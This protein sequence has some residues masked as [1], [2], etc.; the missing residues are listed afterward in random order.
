MH[1]QVD[2]TNCDREPIHLLGRVQEFGFLVAVSQDWV[3]SHASQNI[4]D[5]LG[6]DATSLIGQPSDALLPPDTIHTIRNRL[7]FLN[8]HRGVEVIYDLQLCGTEARFD[9][10]VHRFESVIILEFE[11]A[12]PVEGAANDMA[13]VRNAIDRMAELPSFA[14]V[15][16]HTVRFVKVITGFDRVMLYKFGADETGEVVA[17][18]RKHDLEPFLNLRY[19]ATDIPKQARALYIENPIRLIGSVADEGSPILSDNDETLDLSGSRLRSVSPIHLEYL[20]NMNVGASMSISVIVNGQLWGLIACHHGKRHVPSMRLRNAALLFGH[21]LSLV[22]QTRLS[23]DERA[24]DE[25]VNRLTAH[26]SRTLS[27]DTTTPDLL[28]SSAE[29]FADILNADGYAVVQEKMVVGGGRTPSEED[30]LALCDHLN[31]LPG[32]AVYANHAIETLMPEAKSLI[33]TAA[34]VLAIPIS[35]S[36]RDYL[37][38][39]RAELVQLVNWAGNPEKPVSYGPN[40]A[41][42][43][44]RKSFE[45]WQTT[46]RG[47]S[48]PWTPADV[49]AASQLRVM[50]LE[51]VLRLTDEASRE[52]KLASQKQELL[53]AELNHRVRNI[54][55]L[56]RGLI[57]QTSVGAISTGELVSKLDGRIQALARA[58]DQIT[59]H[60]WAPTALEELIRTEADSYLLDKKDR[61]ETEGPQ[62]LLTSTAYTSMAL[63]IHELMTNSAKYG[64]LTSARGR[65]RIKWTLGNDASLNIEWREVGGPPVKAPERRGFGST[66][67]E[68]TIPFE[69]SGRAD[70]AY[71][72]E[73]VTGKFWIPAEHV[74]LDDVPPAPEQGQKAST[75]MSFG[76][77]ESVLIVEDN[78]MIAMDAEMIFERLG[79]N[80]TAVASTVKAAMDMLDSRSFNFALLDINLGNETSFEVARRLKQIDTPFLFASG[81]GDSLTL[82]EDLEEIRILTKPYDNDMIRSLF[83][84]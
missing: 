71:R 17:E 25:V 27:K 76:A 53:I 19:P 40:G 60:H 10:S 75:L 16:N 11:P 13:N 49:R 57:S 51:V 44:P 72:L 1:N 42:L 83:S 28:R 63:V 55:G 23:A 48:A 56:V 46:V 81:Y 38:F 47:Q 9:A 34:G 58:H 14:A 30:I 78:L 37:L 65:V 4:H 52:R 32:N 18:A 62:V 2:L 73:G 54:L 36:P 41:R 8:P 69:L 45:T 24:N 31:A 70:I 59:R 3:I 67:I 12:T 22:L 26:I 7:Q 5:F 43:T 84:K 61:V 82:P 68:R 29:S 35:R 77:P 6:M 79:C 80:D 64:A 21:M 66:I 39:F 74:V 33:D 15:Y 50:L 20:R